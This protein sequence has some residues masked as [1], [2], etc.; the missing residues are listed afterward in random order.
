MDVRQRSKH[1]LAVALRVRCRKA[2]RQEKGRLLDEFAA[3][4]PKHSCHR[5]HWKASETKETTR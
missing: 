2:T 3:P 1:D 4:A 5:Q